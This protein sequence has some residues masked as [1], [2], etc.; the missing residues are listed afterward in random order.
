[1]VQARPLTLLILPLDGAQPLQR[2]TLTGERISL[3]RERTCTITVTDPAVSRVHL[4]F[5]REGIGWRVTRHEHA[6]PLYVNGKSVDTV[7]LEPG[8]QLVVGGTLLC[9]DET[10]WDADGELTQGRGGAGLTVMARERPQFAVDYQGVCFAVPVRAPACVLGR[11]PDADIV[12]PGLAV[13]ERQASVQ[14]EPDGSCRLHDLGSRNGVFVNGKHISECVLHDGDIVTVGEGAAIGQV[15]LTFVTPMS[16]PNAASA[17]SEHLEAQ[18]SPIVKTPS[19]ARLDWQA[20]DVPQSGQP[21]LIGRSPTAHCP[22]PHPLISWRHAV[23]RREGE[24]VLVEDLHSTNGTYVNYKRIQAPHALKPQD[25]LQFGPYELLFDGTRL[26]ASHAIKTGMRMEIHELSRTIKAGSRRRQL[27]DRVTLVVEPGEMVAIVGGSGAGKTTLLRAMAGV[28]PATGGHVLFDGVDG[29]AH[30]DWV[31]GRI[32]YVPQDD[33]VHG[34]LSVHDA[35]YYTARLRFAQDLDTAELDR[36]ID[37]VLSEL[38]LAHKRDT[39][40]EA[41]SGGERKRVN[42]AVELMCDVPILFLDE[43]NGPLDPH[44]RADMRSFMRELARKGRTVVL[45][46]HMPEDALASDLVAF[47]GQGGKLCFYGPPQ[48]ALSFFG[49]PDL[50]Q[51][52][53]SVAELEQAEQWHQ[54]FTHSSLASQFVSSR[55]TPGALPATS[56]ATTRPSPRRNRALRT[57]RQSGWRQFS[58]LTRRY[59]KIL[60]QDRKNLLVLLLQAPVIAVLLALITSAGVFQSSNG[61]FDAQKVVFLLAV[62]TIWF[63]ISN[64]VREIAKE[65]KIYLRE[66]LAGLKAWPYILSKIVVL[67]GLCTL[68]ALILL[69]AVVART[70]LPAP[71]THLF[72]PPLAEL[73]VT[74]LLAGWAGVALGL[75]VSAFASN[76]DKAISAAPLVLLPQL[77]LAG[78]I[79]PVSGPVQAVSDLT[80]SRWAVQALGTSADLDHL[81]YAELASEPVLVSAPAATASPSTARSGPAAA[82]VPLARPVTQAMPVSH[83]MAADYDTNPAASH[84]TR[85]V[86]ANA[87]WADARASRR[88]HLLLTWGALAALLI[89]F[90]LLAMLRQ[91]RKATA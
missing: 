1:M 44:L 14:L 68:Q 42:V 51:V 7:Q 36:R 62:V 57:R 22:L 23:L 59:V 38:S 60:V 88:Q 69:L 81:Y 77:L 8:V 64:A 10:S 41:L 31:R 79:F 26:L 54:R 20:L 53:K 32:G 6:Q 39:L 70:G 71:G 49:R 75:L 35:L 27:L 4:W 87:S 73:L 74:M 11:R 56:A 58:L 45:V 18:A 29:Y 83:F 9:I 21:L 91:A 46:T 90:T 16:R 3:G 5:V 86:A 33:I 63:G 65:E 78:V 17:T 15:R 28:T 47:L 37:A 19:Q 24:E 2:M 12:L 25:R 50:E 76:P 80:I 61:P 52:Y 34:S 30:P 66:R 48:E 13:S 72:I 67:A 82:S 84:Y 43:P 55:L 89:G 85:S 40:I